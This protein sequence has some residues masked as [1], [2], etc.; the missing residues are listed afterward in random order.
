MTAKNLAQ[1]PRRSPADAVPQGAPR[2]S[3]PAAVTAAANPRDSEALAAQFLR[4][5][6]VLLR[7]VQ[8]Y[9]QH[10]P[11]LIEGLK[12]TGQALDDLLGGA[13]MIGF[14]VERDGLALM[15]QGPRPAH[16]IAD[17][18]GELKA[19][20]DTFRRASIRSLTFVPRTRL[21]E[22]LQFARAVDEACRAGQSPTRTDWPTRLREHR[23]GEIR[24]N[25]APT[26]PGDPLHFGSLLEALLGAGGQNGVTAD[27]VLQR[28]AGTV[29]RGA[30]RLMGLGRTAGARARGSA[31]GSGVCD[32][33]G[34]RHSR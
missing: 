2:R 8:L 32:S 19:L 21:D 33:G 14:T 27:V 30:A 7:A 34:V 15:S 24:V 1:F 25:E 17:R 3:G 18:R 31:A 5:L 26:S 4:S 12:T 20:A 16:A 22:L 29:S 13:P 11:R 10:H 9:H 23:I 6:H 28:R